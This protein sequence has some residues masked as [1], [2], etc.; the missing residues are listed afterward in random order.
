M[1]ERRVLALPGLSY[2]G[3]MAK[4]QAVAL[5]PGRLLSAVVIGVATIFVPKVDPTEHWSIPPTMEFRSPTAQTNL[6]GGPDS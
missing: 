1:P 2:S 3:C 5:L 6:S 4:Q